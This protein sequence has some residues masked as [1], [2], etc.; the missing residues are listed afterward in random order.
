MALVENS[1]Q[2]AWQ[3][4]LWGGVSAMLVALPSAI[5][6]GVTTVAVLG[7]AH[8]AHGALAGVIGAVALGITAAGLGSARQLISAPCAPAA[9]IL[10]ALAATLV[11]QGQAGQSESELAARVMLL[12]TLVGVFAGVIQIVFGIAR[13]GRLIKFIPYP[14]V[15]GYLSG[16]GLMIILAQAPKV[17]GLHAGRE[18]LS[19]LLHPEQWNLNALIIGGVTMLAMT[20][21][22][23]LST[24]V[25][26][27]ITGLGAGL[28]AFGVLALWHPELRAT[29]HNAL[30]VGPMQGSLTD[31]ASMLGGRWQLAANLS[32]EQVFALLTPALTL[33]TLLSI[34]TLKTCVVLDAMSG[35]RTDSNRELLGQG[36]GNLLSALLGGMPGAGTMGPTLVNLNSGGQTRRAGMISGGLILAAF[37]FG[38][39]LIAWL[40]TPALAGILIVLGSRMVDR[41]SLHLLRHRH[42][43]F[44]FTVMAVVVVVALAYNLIAAAG[45]GI[46][47]ALAL[48]MRELIRSSVIRRKLR[49]DQV[50]SH[51]HRQNEEKALLIQ[52]GGQT[53]LCELQGSLFFGTTDQLL[54]ELDAD[55]RNCRYVL[56][57]MRRVQSF[58]FTAG[59][60]LQVI[61]KQVKAHDGFLL[62]C[63]LPTHLAT[64]L[65]LANY[66]RLLGILEDDEHLRLFDNRD[67]ALE[68]VED[69]I[70]AGLATNAV[71]QVLPTLEQIPLFA[72]LKLPEAFTQLRT[73]VEERTVKAGEFIFHKGDMGGELFIL[74]AG[75][76][77]VNLPLKAG[78]HYHL[79]TFSDGHF[80]GDMAFFDRQ[81]R[82]ADAVAVTEAHLFV[83]PRS[84][85]EALAK[86]HPELALEILRRLG[87]EMAIRL[88]F[89]NSELRALHQ[90]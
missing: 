80:F 35:E 82:S 89:A 58:D 83:L 17:F 67:E 86:E 81:P 24:R 43:F 4:D 10:S 52:H 54:T 49:G 45:V 39:P 36:A 32:A 9:A 37:L 41:E 8:L 68:W 69:R 12:M 27:A 14:V 2:P 62:L 76:V 71:P 5:A 60:V 90:S 1:T 59:H 85:F 55:I 72:G 46:G 31:V 20:Q 51:K 66:L 88:R 42:T 25:P 78:H 3:G 57:D 50:S 47:L 87:R 33:A 63:S 38:R 74:R 19:G 61:Y 18:F 15:A 53:V 56:L 22:A 11:T 73:I 28:L 21:A 48:F 16:V 29:V 79:T 13:G 30:V 65:G 44:D 34:D 70:L 75:S 6:Y 7:P 84:R 26:A 64:G 23:R 77:S 40:P